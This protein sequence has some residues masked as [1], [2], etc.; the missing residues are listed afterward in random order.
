MYKIL[1]IEDDNIIA[2]RLTEELSR[3]GYDTRTVGDFGNILKCFAEFSPDMVLLDISLPFYDGY[4]WCRSIR[5]VSG[6]PI[7][8]MSGAGDNMN[9][10]MAMNM[11]ADDFIVKPFNMDVI[12]AK[13]QA[14]IRRTYEFSPALNSAV[15]EHGGI[16]LNM[17][18]ASLSFEG[19]KIGLTKNEYMILE[20]LMRNKG[21]IISREDIMTKLWEDETFIDENTLTVN[22]SRLRRKLAGENISDLIKTKKGMGYIIE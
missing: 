7:I 22:M 16:I 2:E 3:W 6:V 11:G 12:V 21:R 17:T 14:L 8:F 13:V 5:E 20:I 9:I 1:I 19:R 10:V 4:Y 18:D 15:I